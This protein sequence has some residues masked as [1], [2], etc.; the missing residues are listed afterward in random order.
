MPVVALYNVKGEQIGDFELND[1]VFGVEINKSLIHDAIVMLNAN[2]RQGTA[3]VKTRSFV[4]GGGRK[5]Y[6]QK[7]TGRARQG[8]TRAPNWVGGG[9]VFGPAPRDYSYA[10]PKKARRAAL[11]SALT[12]KVQAGE[13]IVV[14][15][16]EVAAPK[17]KE[18]A[19]ILT[20][21][22]V[23]ASSLIVTAGY[24]SNLH[25]STRNIPRVK[26]APAKDINVYDVLY[27]GK[28]I[29][30]KAAVAKVEEVLLD[31]ASA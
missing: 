10:I 2:K 14:D 25:L 19:G 5:P 4:R 6:R 31:A 30:T 26:T 20:N 18:V 29:L 21:L 27:Y 7:G 1:A 22:N 28:V 16:M 9:T 23:G 24:D 3:A 11:R 8:S 15:T 12:A 17:T 13:I